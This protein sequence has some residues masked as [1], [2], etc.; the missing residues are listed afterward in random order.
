MRQKDSESC[1]S[2]AMGSAEVVH[3]YNFLP[4]TVNSHCQLDSIAGPPS[5]LHLGQTLNSNSTRV[6]SSEKPHRLF[7]SSE[8]LNLN[9]EGLW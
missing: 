4:N 3:F 2:P 6:S 8:S 5:V 9:V 1:F 7:H